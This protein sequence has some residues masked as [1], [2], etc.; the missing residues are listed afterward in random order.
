MRVETALKLYV[1]IFSFVI[2]K[3][4]N[5]KTRGLFVDNVETVL[6]LYIGIFGFVINKLSNLKNLW[7]FGTF[8][9][10]VAFKFSYELCL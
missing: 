7:T 1:A 3:L 2:N 9:N 8:A 5:L 4:S 6:K 10:N